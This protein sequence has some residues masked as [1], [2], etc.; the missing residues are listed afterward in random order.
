MNKLRFVIDTNIL[1]SSILS[2]NTPPQKLFDYSMAHGIILMSEATVTEITEVLTRKKFDRY[3]S[4]VKRSKF[5]QTLA[6]KIEAI[7]I[8]ESINICRDHKDDKFLEVAVNGKAD[9]LITGDHDLLVLHPFRDIQ[10][11]TPADFLEL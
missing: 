5:L 4:L 7:E 6:S 8:T 10:I 2:K 3:V 1:I 11:L 9:Y